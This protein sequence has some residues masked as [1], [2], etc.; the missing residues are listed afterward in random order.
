M[1]KSARR[2][3]AKPTKQTAGGRVRELIGAITGR[4]RTAETKRRPARTRGAARTT[5]GKARRPVKRR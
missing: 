2:K 3:S 5:R 1:L 4:K